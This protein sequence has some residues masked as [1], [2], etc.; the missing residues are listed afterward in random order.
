[1]ADWLQLVPRSATELSEV[2]QPGIIKGQ[3]GMAPHSIDAAEQLQKSLRRNSLDYQLSARPSYDELVEAGIV[4]GQPGMA[5]RNIEA[6]EQLQKSLRRDSLAQQLASRP[7]CEE[8]VAA[9]I[10]RGTR[11][12]RR[13]WSM[14]RRSCR[15]RLERP[16]STSSSVLA[17]RTRSWSSLASPRVSGEWR[18]A[19]S[20][21][22]S[23][24]SRFAGTH[25]IAGLTSDYEE[26]VEAGIA[27]GSGEW[28][29]AT[30][31]LLSSCRSR[32]AAT[33]SITS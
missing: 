19:T 15:C 7:E 16:R 20:T 2:Q 30:S 5:P 13:A 22:L 26:L 9:G 32:F 23:S 27:K 3:R 17:R 10:A 21:L 8:L 11:T 29:R 18:R 6:A 25:W 28:R 33:R 31:T 12:L 4:K 24:C 14:P 1:M